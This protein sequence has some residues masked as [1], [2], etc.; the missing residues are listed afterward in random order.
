LFCR[1]NIIQVV[2]FP[3]SVIEIESVT[4]MNATYSIR[5]VQHLS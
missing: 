5:I 2:S 3:L 4:K 1:S